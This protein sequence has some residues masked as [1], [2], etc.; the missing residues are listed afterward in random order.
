MAK[1]GIKVKD[2][3]R[4]LGLTSRQLIDRCRAEGLHVQNSIT[5]LNPESERTVRGWFARVARA[6]ARG[7]GE[8]AS[9]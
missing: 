7:P 4:E 2:I 5:K 8:P 6:K 1:K 9:P 3:A